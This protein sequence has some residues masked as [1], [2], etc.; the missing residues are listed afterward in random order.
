MS[1]DQPFQPATQPAGPALDA[2]AGGHR[3]GPRRDGGVRIRQVDR[4]RGHRP[5]PAGAVRGRRRLP[6]PANIAKM[7]SG[8]ALD[9]DDRQPVARGDRGVARPATPTAA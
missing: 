7:T 5:A 6:P 4:R 9:D 2:A 3:P 8:Q 1:S